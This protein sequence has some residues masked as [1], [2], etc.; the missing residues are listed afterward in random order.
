[1]IVDLR[2]LIQKYSAASGLLFV[3]LLSI[4]LVG[5][6]SRI[7]FFAAFTAPA[8]LLL[9][10]MDV[11]PST[12]WDGSWRQGAFDK[13]SPFETSRL[14]MVMKPGR[15]LDLTSVSYYILR[16]VYI[17]LPPLRIPPCAGLGIPDG[18]VAQ[19][20]GAALC[21]HRESGPMK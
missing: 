6:E 14:T 13:T 19:C 16:N 4:S 15:T 17:F 18:F 21:R 9:S 1:M 5:Y 7:H 3:M 20:H 11:S 12:I 2:V 10:Q 8:M